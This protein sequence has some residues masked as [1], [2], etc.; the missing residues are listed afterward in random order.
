M[1]DAHGENECA[2]LSETVPS[3]VHDVVVK[4]IDSD[5]MA[6]IGRKCVGAVPKK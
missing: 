4:V 5:V 2:I 1:G 3:W 6:N